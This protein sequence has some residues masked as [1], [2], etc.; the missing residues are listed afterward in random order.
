MSHN[1]RDCKSHKAELERLWRLIV[2]KANEISHPRQR[3]FTVIADVHRVSRGAG[4]T[5]RFDM[6]PKHPSKDGNSTKPLIFYNVPH[7]R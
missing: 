1:T 6:I 5:L 3:E 2:W 7:V 4:L